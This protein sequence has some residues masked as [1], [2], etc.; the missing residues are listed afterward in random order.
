MAKKIVIIISVFAVVC[1]SLAFAFAPMNASAQT[2]Y[3]SRITTWN[4]SGYLVSLSRYKGVYTSLPSLSTWNTTNFTDSVYNARINVSAN[5]LTQSPFGEYYYKSV[6]FT[7]SPACNGSSANVIPFTNL[8]NSGEYGKKYVGDS[9]Q[10]ALWGTN[11][12]M[13]SAVIVSAD[14]YFNVGNVVSCTVSFSDTLLSTILPLT[15]WA[16]TVSGSLPTSSPVQAIQYL[17]TDNNGRRLAFIFPW[18]NY[19]Q[20]NYSDSTVYFKDLDDNQLFQNGFNQG[21]QQGYVTGNSDGYNNGYSVGKTDGTDIG[22]SSGYNDGLL[23]ANDY[24]FLQLFTSVVQ[25]PVDIFKSMFDFE[26]L[27]FNLSH[28]L[29]ALLSVGLIIA[30]VSRIKS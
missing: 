21:Y 13:S 19:G 8:G 17:F 26:I 18:S 4:A 5:G 22:Y 25:A 20:S 14:S 16:Y 9:F 23:A 15:E 6:V 28:F 10:F 11:E 24:S 7:I 2:S 29:T 12:T 1:G 30:I 3:P 27:G